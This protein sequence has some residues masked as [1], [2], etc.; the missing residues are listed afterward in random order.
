VY[1]TYKLAEEM[2]DDQEKDG[3]KIPL[4]MEQV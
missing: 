1:N 3:G 2:Q 4:N